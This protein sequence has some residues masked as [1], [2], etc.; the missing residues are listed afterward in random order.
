[1]ESEYR[2][3]ADAIRNHADAHPKSRFLVAIAG[4]PG[5][6]KTTTA[7]A[8]V[9]QLNQNSTSRAALLSM[10]GFHLSRAALDQLPNPKEAH[11]RRGAPWTFDVSRF[12]AFISRLRTWA[13]ET[14]LAAP[15]SGTWS[16]ED[17]ICAPT[18]DHEA[19][20]PV[21][22]GISITP[23]ASIIIIEGNYL[24]LDEPGWCELAALV[25]YRVFVDSDPLEARSRLAE[26]HLR[27]GIEKTLEDGYRRVD[28]ND[29]LNAM[30]I[31]EKLLATDMIVKSVTLDGI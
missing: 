16:P 14:P 25:D 27:A 2:R 31:R 28:S 15:Y 18:F 21:E 1:M 23:D 9:Q 24:L 5:S 10:D 17:V 30:S 11:I 7:E 29:S 22:D 3:L 6:G 26:R 12:V 19:K 20:D 13:D 4:I 8:V